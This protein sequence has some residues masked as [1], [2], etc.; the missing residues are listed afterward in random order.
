MASA[1][2]G[3]TE[4]LEVATNCRNAVTAVRWDSRATGGGMADI[5]GRSKAELVGPV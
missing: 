5:V 2:L 4:L 1:S 3:S